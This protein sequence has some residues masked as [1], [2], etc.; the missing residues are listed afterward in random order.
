MKRKRTAILVLLVLFP[1]VLLV[2]V[3]MRAKNGELRADL[4]VTNA[5]IGIPGIS[6]MY[7]A[8]LTNRGLLPVR[9]TRCNF[10]DDT[11][12][13]GT[14]VAYAV[15]RWD[16]G[17]KRWATVV[18]WRQS[19]FCKPYPLGIVEA[20]LTRSWLWP[21]QKLSTGEEATA[22]RDGFNVGDRGRFVVFTGTPG[23]YSS[24]VLT[25]EFVIDERPQTDVPLRVRH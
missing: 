23:D 22:A 3:V 2:S 15:Q 20:N 8:T 25:S 24:A 9:V 10:I 12:S 14:N 16:G 1:A 17:S 6:K 21:G 5:D 11:L 19:E 4:V 18:E 7:E 13:P